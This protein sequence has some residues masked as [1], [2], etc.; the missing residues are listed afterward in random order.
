MLGRAFDPINN[1]NVPSDDV[2]SKTCCLVTFSSCFLVLQSV[3]A[4]C[5][6]EP[7]SGENQYLVEWRPVDFVKSPVELGKWRM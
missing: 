5:S 7:M 1:I 4:Q 2:K 3:G 6:S